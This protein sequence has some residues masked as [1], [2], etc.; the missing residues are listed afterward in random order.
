MNQKIVN[1]F[2]FQEIMAKKPPELLSR[3]N[4][5]QSLKLRISLKIADSADLMTFR[6][7]K[8]Y[9]AYHLY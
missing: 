6:L 1:K 9:T 7:S 5:A 3:A 8:P 2:E 4:F